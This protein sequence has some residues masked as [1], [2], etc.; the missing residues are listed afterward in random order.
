MEKL[1]AVPSFSLIFEPQTWLIIF[2]GVVV[3]AVVLQVFL[4][5]LLTEAIRHEFPAEFRIPKI[6]FFKMGAPR[7]RTTAGDRSSGNILPH[8]KPTEFGGLGP[9]MASLCTSS[10]VT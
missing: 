9:N 3:L 2:G 4:Y 10:R 8:V 6:L 5:W 7:K 1:L